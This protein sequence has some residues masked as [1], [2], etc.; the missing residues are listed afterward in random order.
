MRKS[1][2]NHEL[3]IVSWNEYGAAHVKGNDPYIVVL[4][5]SSCDLI[6]AKLLFHCVMA[7]FFILQESNN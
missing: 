4:L 7:F 5:T 2:N 6:P 3:L 1:Q